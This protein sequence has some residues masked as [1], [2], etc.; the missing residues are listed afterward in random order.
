MAQVTETKASDEEDDNW[1]ED[2]EEGISVSKIAALD[3]DVENTGDTIATRSSGSD[4]NLG[5][6]KPTRAVPKVAMNGKGMEAI[7]EDYS[8]L[9]ADDNKMFHGR[10]ASLRVSSLASHL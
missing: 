2:F 7:P 4:D 1:D 9:I 3:K 5:T 6:I 10:I 8:D